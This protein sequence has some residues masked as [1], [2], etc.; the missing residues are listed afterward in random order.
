MELQNEVISGWSDILKFELYHHSARGNHCFSLCCSACCH[1]SQV[2]FNTFIYCRS[3]HMFEGDK[4]CCISLSVSW[5]I[6]VCKN[7]YI[8]IKRQV[9]LDQSSSFFL[10][11]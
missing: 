3:S 11:D 6:C 9:T 8:F 7:S 10:S 5:K 4:L 2:G 1:A